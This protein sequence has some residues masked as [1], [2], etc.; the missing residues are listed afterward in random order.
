MP[1]CIIGNGTKVKNN[2]MRQY[3]IS[4]KKY[5]AY[6]GLFICENGAKIVEFFGSTLDWSFFMNNI[7]KP[8]KSRQPH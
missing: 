4:N 6:R 3:D 8:P 2:K 5:G 1:L 7:L